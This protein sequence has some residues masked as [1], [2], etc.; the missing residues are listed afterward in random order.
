M[1][2]RI[3]LMI[4]AEPQRRHW[5]RTSDVMLGDG[6]RLA[7]RFQRPHLAHADAV[8]HHVDVRVRRLCRHGSPFTVVANG[9]SV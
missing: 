3:A 9:P 4:P 6:R 8:E 5:D 2:A 1:D 7:L